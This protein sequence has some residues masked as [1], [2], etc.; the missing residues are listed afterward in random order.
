MAAK[1]AKKAASD[2]V[3]LTFMIDNQANLDGINATIA[4]FEKKT[5][6]KTEVDLRPNGAEGDN[7]I[8]TRLA[9]GDMDDIFLY[10]TGSLF[11]VLNPAQNMV[12]L[13]SEAYVASFDNGFKSTVTDKGRVY[14]IPSGSSFGG[15]W[16]YNKKVYAKLGLK[17]PKTWNEL[18]A[19]CEKIKAAKIVPVIGSYKDSWTAQLILLSDYYNVQAKVPSFADNFTANKAKFATTPAALR[20]WEKQQQIYKLGYMNKEFLTTNLDAGLKMLANGQGAMYPQLT[21]QLPLIEKNYPSKV[22]DI[23]FF[24]QPGDSASING[25]TVWEPSGIY[26]YKNS[27]NIDAA[28]QWLKFFISPEAIAIQA[29]KIKPQGP[30]VIKG[31]KLPAD[32]YTAVKD[33]LPYFN[34]GKTCPALEFISP[35]KGPNCAQITVQNGSGVNTPKQNAAEYDK[36]VEKQAKQLGV[37]GW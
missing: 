8:K 11:K 31:A 24:P 29:A 14:G 33:M 32:S 5:G 7:F 21:V 26:I 4:A 34:A 6:I 1:A 10:N 13:T 30:Y 20:A 15:G 9:T 16:L 37:A 17:V 2:P 23:G 22:N 12:D 19:N 35:L 3:T 28:K 36:D 27:K 18:L 25:I